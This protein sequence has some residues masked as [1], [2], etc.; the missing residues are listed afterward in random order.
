MCP[1][2]PGAA[3]PITGCKSPE[4]DE[5]AERLGG[6]ITPGK[7][8]PETGTIFALLVVTEAKGGMPDAV[9]EVA[10]DRLV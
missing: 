7:P 1:L 2:V 5:G 3:N 4:L 6:P 9:S 8:P 10:V